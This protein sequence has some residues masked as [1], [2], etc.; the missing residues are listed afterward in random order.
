MNPQIHPETPAL[1]PPVW[2]VDAV[3][4]DAWRD[5]SYASSLP[6][7]AVICCA[8]PDAAAFLQGQITA[9][10]VGLDETR[11]QYAGLCDPKGRLLAVFFLWRRGSAFYLA[12]PAELA[13][14]LVKRL[15][16]YVLRAK[17]TIALD[18]T[19][20]LT[21][22]CH[23]PEALPAP[24]AGMSGPLA[25]WQRHDDASGAV[26]LGLGTDPS[27]MHRLLLASQAPARPD[28]GPSEALWW[29]GQIQSAHPMVFAATSACFVPQGINLEVLGGV[30]FRKGCYTGQ[31][32]VARS[33][34]L[35]KLRRRLHIGAVQAPAH[36]ADIFLRGQSQPLGRVL[37]SATL[38]SGQT[39]FLF[40]CPTDR[41]E[42]QLLCL[43]SGDGPLV[44]RMALPYQLFDPTA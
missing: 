35:G 25:L 21:G 2:L 4:Q 36:A 39:R 10:A 22:V 34:Y 5:A 8:G 16:L 27:G 13:E 26:A 12:L 15:R 20:Q 23:S 40:E 44:D 30:S 37:M 38:T 31:E 17:V 29:L 28:P 7:L 3:Q 43:G 32:V 24:L 18:P 14:G 19:L 1:V 41:L 6:T 11:W 33:Q 9:D 42:G